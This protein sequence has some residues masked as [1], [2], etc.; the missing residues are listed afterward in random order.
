MEIG[1]LVYN[2]YH[3]LLRFGTIKS[4]RID[5]KSHCGWAYYKVKWHSDNAYEKAIKHREELTNKKYKIEEYRK[6][7]IHLVSKDFLISV[8]KGHENES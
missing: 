8:I 6:D 3:G 7:Q 1:A 5:T 2:R 4:K